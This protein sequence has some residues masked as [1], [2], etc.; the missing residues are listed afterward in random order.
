MAKPALP[1][2]APSV[3]AAACNVKLWLLVLSMFFVNLGVSFGQYWPTIA[4]T[5]TGSRKSA[6][7][8]SLPPFFLAAVVGWV[9]ARASDRSGRQCVVLLP[10][11]L[12][13]AASRMPS[14]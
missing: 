13:I 4:R 6:L 2:S 9:S 14:D 8:I 7:L 3:L 1:Q 11:A 12:T 10:S 5:L